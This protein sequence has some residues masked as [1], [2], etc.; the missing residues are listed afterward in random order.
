[1]E[2]RERKREAEKEREKIRGLILMKERTI[3]G[4]VLEIISTGDIDRLVLSSPFSLNLK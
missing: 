3:K 1:M 4:L 2:K